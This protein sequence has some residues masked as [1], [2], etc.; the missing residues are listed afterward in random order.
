[1]TQF[2]RAPAFTRTLNPSRGRWSREMLN[3]LLRLSVKARHGLHIDIPSLRKQ[4]ALLDRQAPD[5]LPPEVR[6][7]PVT[8]NGVAARWLL[9]KG[10][11]RERVLLYLHGG[12]FVANTP[13][14]Y[15][16]MVASWCQSLKARALLVD[17]RLA[18]EHPHPAALED[19]L[20][21]YSW[22][23][24]QGVKAKDIV[25]AGDSAGGNLVIATLQR[26]KAE[27]QPLPSCAV[28]LSPFLDFTLSGASALDNARHD[29]I[30]T[31]AFA[32][33]IRGFYAPGER[34][35]EPSVS[36]LFGAFEGLP[37]MLFQVGSTEMLLDDAVRA[38]AKAHAAGVPVR[39]EVWHRL[40][41]V[42]Q[43]IAALPQ[44]QLAARS[45]QGFIN[46]HTD[47]DH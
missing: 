46:D 4:F 1:M 7:E 2:I 37:P 16:A 27:C 6:S 42:F 15:A 21:A 17:Y 30:F 5:S 43:M 20:D 13:A 11:R 39:L 45:I 9:P 8:C 38:A 33:G 26:L 10:R 41:H 36:P 47:W 34:H 35:G 22:L 31:P 19:C 3:L 14:V 24:D 44:A 28:L 25:I 40:P 12:A 18:P 29:P 32:I 23:L